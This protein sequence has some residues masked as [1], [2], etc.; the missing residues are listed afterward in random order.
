MYR[1]IG[2]KAYSTSAYYN[3]L[4]QLILVAKVHASPAWQEWSLKAAGLREF[5]LPAL[6]NELREIFIPT[7]QRIVKATT[8]K[9]N[10]EYSVGKIVVFHHRVHRMEVWL[11]DNL[12]PTSRYYAQPPLPPI[13]KYQDVY[14]PPLFTTSI[15]LRY[16]HTTSW[17]RNLLALQMTKLGGLQLSQKTRDSWRMKSLPFSSLWSRSSYSLVFLVK[18]WHTTFVLR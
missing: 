9:L 13:T 18:S 10:R 1:N 7:I 12:E 8:S 6:D 5:G 14:N 2:S 15:A 4:K 16:W 3:Y 11:E 17:P